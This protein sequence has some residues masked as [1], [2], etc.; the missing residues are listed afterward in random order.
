MKGGLEHL[1]LECSSFLKLADGNEELVQI[2][3]LG[4]FIQA[5]LLGS[6]TGIEARN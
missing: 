6:N 5:T 4:A 2:Q 1:F 3:L